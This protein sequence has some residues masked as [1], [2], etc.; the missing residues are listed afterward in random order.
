MLG[1]Q[2]V[3]WTL[4]GGTGLAAVFLLVLWEGLLGGAAYVNTF[5][6]ISRDE[7]IADTAREFAL[8]ITSVADSIS[9]AMAGFAALPLHNWICN[10]PLSKSTD[11]IGNKYR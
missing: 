5:H 7:D 4:G 1:F 10:L 6:N 9:I 3:T 11:K 2:A 8:G